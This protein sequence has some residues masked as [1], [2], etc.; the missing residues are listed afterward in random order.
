[1]AVCLSIND[2]VFVGFGPVPNVGDTLPIV[3]GLGVFFGIGAEVADAMS[4]GRISFH[5]TES[6]AN[7]ESLGMMVHDSGVSL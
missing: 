1:M 5:G 4:I 6:A 3:I 2:P 7:S